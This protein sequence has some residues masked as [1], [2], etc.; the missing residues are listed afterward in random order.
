MTNLKETQVVIRSWIVTIMLVI[1][2]L[3]TLKLR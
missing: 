3:I 2:G 1:V